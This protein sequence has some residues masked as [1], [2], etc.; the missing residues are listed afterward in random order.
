[1][2]KY[3]NEK[4]LND[5]KINKKMTS[6]EERCVKTLLFDSIPIEN[7]ICSLLHVEIGDGNKIVYSY[8]EST[9]ERIE[10]ICEDELNMV[11]F[12][13]NFKNKQY[14]K[15]INNSSPSLAKLRL[16]RQSIQFFF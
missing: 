5:Q 12:L 11:N 10:P 15:W 16:E 1:M 3:L 9:N 14:D 2:N 7:Y 4:S 6:H 13:I 8:F